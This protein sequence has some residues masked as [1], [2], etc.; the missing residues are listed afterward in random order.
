MRC[1]YI[2]L[3]TAI[4]QSCCP[5]YLH[6]DETH[7]HQHIGSPCPLLFSKDPN[8]SP[9]LPAADSLCQDWE[10]TSTATTSPIPSGQHVRIC[11][12]LLCLPEL[13][14]SRN[15]FLQNHD[16]RQLEYSMRPKPPR[17]IHRCPGR[18]MCPLSIT[19]RAAMSPT[20]WIDIAPLP[21]KHPDYHLSTAYTGRKHVPVLGSNRQGHIK[22]TLDSFPDGD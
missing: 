6:H 5:F 4:I 13:Y 12:I 21:S 19:R 10:S 8:I 7:R 14:G 17:T 16:G 18:N 22:P 9:S 2:I 11:Q 3:W 1:E 15:A 20:C